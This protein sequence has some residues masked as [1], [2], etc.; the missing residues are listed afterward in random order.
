MCLGWLEPNVIISVEL[1]SSFRSLASFS[2]TYVLW[3]PESNN[4]RIDVDEL[5]EVLF[6]VD[7]AVCINT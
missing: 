7:V 6:T 2:V 5:P 1:S 4:M 3:L